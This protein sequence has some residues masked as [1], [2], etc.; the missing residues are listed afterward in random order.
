MA[1]PDFICANWSPDRSGASCKEVGRYSCKNCLLVVYCGPTCQKSHWALHKTDC[2]SPLGKETWTPDW[3]L[4][5]R[6]PA[7]VQGGIGSAFGGKKYL[8]G[9]IPSLDVLQL[10]SNEGNNYTGQLN[11]LFAASGDLR[12]VAK[13]I[14]MLPSSYN[15][16]ISITINDLDPDIVARNVI[17]LLIALT[18]ENSDEAIDCI[19]HIWYSALIRKSDLE[20][21][22]QRIRP[23]IES[24]CEKTKNKTPT[25]LLGK[26]WT[27]GQR[28]LRLVLEKSSWDNLLSYMDIP[29]G[30]T[31][32]RANQIRTAITLAESRKD[33]RDRYLLFQT[34]SRRIAKNRYWG[35]GLLLPFG[36]PRVDFQE[37]NPTFFQTA[38]T[39]PLRD[40]SDPLNGWSLKEVESRSSGAA[41]ADIY[42]RLFYYIRTEIRAFLLRL[43]GLEVSFRLF[44]M[45][46]A[47]LPDH[48][49]AS[50]FSRIEV[51][52]ISDG[53]YL[54]I[55]RTVFF[56]VPLLQ[57][58]LVNPHA[59]LI[60]LFMNA[61]D[62]NLTTRDQ[63]SGMSPHSPE[64]K[65]LLK[66]LPTT[67]MGMT[68]NPSS[69]EI[70][71]FLFARNIVVTYDH[72][73]N[74]CVNN[75]EFSETAQCVGAA[76]KEKHTVIEKWPFKLKLRPG[77]PGAQKEF[78]R[79]LSGGVSGKERYVEWK[80]I[81]A[82]DKLG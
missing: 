18:V 46:A 36:S 70:I 50:S 30:L 42:G 55:H 68:M 75:L 66:Y 58:P 3:V 12:N 15:Q 40:N 67:N 8:W 80:R 79:L 14:A 31:M 32:E 26:T 63:L 29:A 11:L 65:R 34:P 21:L 13:T 39:W 16:P 82:D 44:Q 41:S 25:S 71:K 6:K 38:D 64:R 5:N 43:S 45:N 72:I 47:D 27:F 52:N 17:I 51:A 48:L 69:P 10:G 4:E 1:T 20:I 74:R 19:I 28:S 9:N 56:M 7:F 57:G 77:Q 54:G 60:T 33:Y 81:S 73:F 76:M 53:G 61:V 24:V 37:P 49:E 22:Q 62:E 2:K 78:D 23:L 35:D 59:T